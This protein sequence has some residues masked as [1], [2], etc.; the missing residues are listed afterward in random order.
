MKNK[1]QFAIR[2]ILIL[3]ILAL[4]GVIG[5]ELSLA[6][7]GEELYFPET[8]HRVAGEFAVV[9]RDTPEALLVF[10]YPITEAYQD[11][12]T[13]LIVQYFQRMR[14]ELHPEASTP[15]QRVVLSPLGKYLYRPGQQLPLPGGRSACETFEANGF[16]VCY[17]FLDFFKEHGG[18]QQFGYPISNIEAHDERIVQYFERARFEWHPELP[19]GQRV[20][21]TDLGARYFHQ[22]GENPV[23]LLPVADS[24]LVPTILGLKVQ[25]FPKY[26]VSGRSGKQ[27]VFVTV[28]DQNSQPVPGA[29]LL[30]AVNTPSGEQSRYVMPGTDANGISQFEF[31]YES[32]ATGVAELEI[33]ATFNGIEEETVSS[34]RI[35]W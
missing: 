23:R 28:R 20:T 14:F 27:T 17:A 12:V 8:G 1:G 16:L 9:Y 10:G 24:N 32:D 5:G 25:A 2:C 30:L 19:P 26:P 6:Q 22:R 29:Q 11:S 18:V 34:F 21:L 7:V 33:L 4:T 3:L 35:W 31:P 13:G 15:E